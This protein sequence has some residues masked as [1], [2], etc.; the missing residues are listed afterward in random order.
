M[1]QCAS[2]LLTGG[3]KLAQRVVVVY[4]LRSC[5]TTTTQ[6]TAQT[7]CVALRINNSSTLHL[8][9]ATARPWPRVPYP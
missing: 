4:T 2:L 8:R 6:T 5:T 1:A 9:Y 7:R 3:A